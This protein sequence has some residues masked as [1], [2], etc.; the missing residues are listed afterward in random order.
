MSGSLS[1]PIKLESLEIRAAIG[2]FL[3]PRRVILM[4]NGS[5][6][7]TAPEDPLSCLPYLDTSTDQEIMLT[8]ANN[9]FKSKNS[10]WMFPVRENFPDPQLR[11]ELDIPSPSQDLRLPPVTAQT[12]VVGVHLSVFSIRH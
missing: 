10:D 3:K 7:I 4:R 6:K 11:A 9:Q 1:R 8:V 5:W 12:H 2:I